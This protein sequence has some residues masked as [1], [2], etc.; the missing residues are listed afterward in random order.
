[1]HTRPCRLRPPGIWRG[2]HRRALRAGQRRSGTASRCPPRR[3]SSPCTTR[4]WP[5]P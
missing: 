4:R 2:A 5:P 3:C 1:M